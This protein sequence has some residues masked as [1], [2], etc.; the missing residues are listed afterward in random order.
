MNADGDLS[1]SFPSPSPPSKP[2]APPAP[3]PAVGNPPLANQSPP[4]K[5]SGGKGPPA[6]EAQ[7][8]SMA[9]GI[10][11]G[12]AEEADDDDDDIGEEEWEDHNSIS[13]GVAGKFLAAGGIAGAGAS[14]ACLSRQTLNTPS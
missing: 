12:E 7:H 1:P 3:P 11:P 5:G 6:L 9:G 14:E 4:P 10:F 13:V 2:P 8:H